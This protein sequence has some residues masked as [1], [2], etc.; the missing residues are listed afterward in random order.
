MQTSLAILL[1]LRSDGL[2]STKAQKEK[3]YFV[4]TTN[5]NSYATYEYYE[6]GKLK[7]K[8]VFNDSV[9]VFEYLYAEDGSLTER[10]SYQKAG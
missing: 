6:S 8:A 10:I 1:S 7:R 3:E 5:G 2:S 4:G 9:L